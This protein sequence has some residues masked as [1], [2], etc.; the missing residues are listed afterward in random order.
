MYGCTGTLCAKSPVW[1]Y[2]EARVIQNTHSNPD[3]SMTSYIGVTS[4]RLLIHTRG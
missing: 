2:K 3:R 4:D 1:W